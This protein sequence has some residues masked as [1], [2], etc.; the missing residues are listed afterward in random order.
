MLVSRLLAEDM[1]SFGA[2]YLDDGAIMAQFSELRHKDG[3][4]RWA[5]TG[6]MPKHPQ[7]PLVP[8]RP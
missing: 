4:V 5:E 1:V 2:V 6:F 7:C 8:I 3:A